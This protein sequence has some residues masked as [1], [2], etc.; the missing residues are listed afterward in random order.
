[1]DS[2]TI[3]AISSAKE[4]SVYGSIPVCAVVRVVYIRNFTLGF[5]LM[6]MIFDLPVFQEVI[7]SI[8]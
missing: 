4:I 5:I 6:P 2:Y 3:D 7:I 1:M 8:W